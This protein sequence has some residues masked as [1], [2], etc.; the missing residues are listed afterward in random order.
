MFRKAAVMDHPPMVHEGSRT[1][2]LVRTYQSVWCIY[3]RQAGASWSTVQWFYCL[4][5]CTAYCFTRHRTCDYLRI[6]NALFVS[7]YLLGLKIVPARP[8]DYNTCWVLRSAGMNSCC[9]SCSVGMS[10]RKFPSCLLLV[11]YDRS[12]SDPDSLTEGFFLR[13]R[14]TVSSGAPSSR[15]YLC[16]PSS[17]INIWKIPTLLRTKIKI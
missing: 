2:D 5:R 15:W 8:T 1:V 7:L 13:R 14:F 12:I 4:L 11:L 16:F 6:R 3:C 9:D 10:E 17:K